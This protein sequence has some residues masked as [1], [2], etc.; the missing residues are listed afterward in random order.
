MR[1]IFVI[2]TAQGKNGIVETNKK[3][4]ASL[5][6]NVNLQLKVVRF[7]HFPF[8]IFKERSVNIIC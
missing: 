4:K 8:N 3:N 5:S 7:H 2:G 6:V 1:I